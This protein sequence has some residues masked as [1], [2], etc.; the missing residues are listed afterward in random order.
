MLDTTTEIS[1]QP[2][3]PLVADGIEQLSPEALRQRVRDYAAAHAVSLRSIGVLCQVAGESTFTAWVSGKYKG[4]NEAIDKKVRIWLRHEDQ[5]SR[6]KAVLPVDVKFAQTPTAVKFLTALEYAQALP[7]IIVISGGAGVGK[8]SAIHHYRDTRPNVWVLTAE[9]LLSSHSKMM[10]YLREVL[11]IPETGRHK[12]SRAVAQKLQGTQGLIIIDEAQHLTPKCMDQMRSVFDRAG[13]G[14]A[15]VGNEEVWARIDGGG[16][17][18]GYSQVFSR[19]GMR[20]TVARPT[21][22]DIEVLLDAAEVVGAAPRAV[23][24]TLGQK[25]GGLR[26]MVKTL[27]AGR[28]AASGAGQELTDEHVIAAWSRRMGAQDGV[29]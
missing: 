13:V 24:R 25:P 23:L 1:T 6:Q 20:V 27:R 16:H 19:V 3:V 12:V 5:V 10:E 28:L 21:T 11:G 14:L 29:L 4:D 17:K 8:T 22:K 9:P 15:L 18:A 2:N 7:D 26:G